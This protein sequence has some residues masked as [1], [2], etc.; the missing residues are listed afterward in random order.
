[1]TDKRQFRSHPTNKREAHRMLKEQGCPQWSPDQLKPSNLCAYCGHPG[2]D[3]PGFEVNPMM[4]LRCDGVDNN[5]DPCRCGGWCAEVLERQHEHLIQVGF[6][7]VE[8][9]EVPDIP[10]VTPVVVPQVDP[11]R[12]DFCARCG[13][14]G[15]PELVKQVHS[16]WRK[17]VRGPWEGQ[18]YCPACVPWVLM[19]IP[20]PHDPPPLVDDFERLR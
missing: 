9:D 12:M 5:G 18:V 13:A 15:H 17:G 3:H 1:M 19:T 16:G 4:A 6:A 14:P 7:V 8:N 10:F 11:D 2:G 20:E